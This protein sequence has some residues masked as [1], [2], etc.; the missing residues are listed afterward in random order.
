[1]SKQI[2]VFV[3]DEGIREKLVGLIRCI[4]DN[5]VIRLAKNYSDAYKM[6]L[7][8]N[9]DTVICCA[10]NE[11][12]QYALPAVYRFIEMIRSVVHYYFTPIILVSN[13]E[14]PTNYCFRELHCFDVI[15]YP[16]YEERFIRS[17][18]KALCFTPITREE[19]MLYIQEQ[20]VVYPIRCSQIGYIQSA[21]HVMEVA[22]KNGSRRMLRYC[23]MQQL[24]DVADVGFLMQ[25]ARS[26]IINT[27]YIQCIDYTNR[28]VTMQNR[29]RLPIGPT[30]VKVMQERFQKIQT[31]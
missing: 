10:V 13:V 19:K 9:V 30:Y 11:Q 17:L 12:H 28:V 8:H 15:E 20:N 16:I 26:V 18:Q 27:N 6:V 2:L 21:N 31:R 23:T 29:E 7:E 14:D 5:L 3:R 22:L 25:C 4:S 1:M 24:L